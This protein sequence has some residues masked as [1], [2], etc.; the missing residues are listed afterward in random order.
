MAAPGCELP[1]CVH[2]GRGCDWTGGGDQYTRHP[3]NTSSPLLAT[4]GQAQTL[5]R[6]QLDQLQGAQPVDQDIG[7]K[8]GCPTRIDLLQSQY[9]LATGHGI[10]HKGMQQIVE[11]Q[12]ARNHPIDDFIGITAVEKRLPARG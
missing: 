8:V 5:L 11:A 7:G 12:D 4:L 10:L 9:C 2:L 6:I 1:A 3:V